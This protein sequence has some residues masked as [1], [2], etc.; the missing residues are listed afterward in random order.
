MK[1]IKRTLRAALMAVTLGGM[2]FQMGGCDVTSPEFQDAFRTGYDIG[3]EIG[4]LL[5]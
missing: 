3:S 5:F 2:A 4:S 1:M